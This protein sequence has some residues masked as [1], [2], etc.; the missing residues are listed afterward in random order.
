MPKLQEM[1]PMSMDYVKKMWDHQIRDKKQVERMTKCLC[2]QNA[3]VPL[4][5]QNRCYFQ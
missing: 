4:L 1:L 2:P 5:K 3:A